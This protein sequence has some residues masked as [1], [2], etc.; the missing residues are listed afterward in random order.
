MNS[1]S[2]SNLYQN[3]VS[4]Y[5]KLLLHQV[6]KSWQILY[7][8]THTKERFAEFLLDFNSNRLYT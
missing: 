6:I 3:D 5:E 7:D 1:N 4:K 8:M 2:N